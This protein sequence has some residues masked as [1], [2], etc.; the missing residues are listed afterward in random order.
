MIE[1]I[2]IHNFKSVDNLC[3]ILDNFNCLIGMNGVGKSTILQAIDFISQIMSGHVQ[4]W[5]D[6]RGWFSSD[7]GS[8]LI[9]K[10]HFIFS[11]SF[12]TKSG[13]DLK[14]DAKLDGVNSKCINERIYI[15]GQRCFVVSNELFVINKKKY[16]CSFIYQGSL[17]S[18]LKESELPEEILEF[19]T[20]LCSIRSLELLSPQLMR[21]RTRTS[22]QDIS[23]G[24]EKLSAYLHGIKGEKRERLVGLLKQFYPNL[25]DFKVTSQR[26]GWK[27]LSVIERYGE[28]N[29]ETEASHLSDGLLRI[30]A[31]LAQRESDKSLIMLDEIEN[32]INQEIVAK[33][34]EILLNAPQQILVTTHSPLILNYLE[35]DVAR[36][37]ALFMYKTPKG[38]SRM[39]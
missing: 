29:L 6:G 4:D 17:L 18:Q 31:I 28:R 24:G 26:A 11:V 20:A 12:R 34:V 21:K 2:E 13:D 30:L 27:K 35:D 9:K 1:K 37:A 7:L 25:I 10:R 8:K 38:Q 16:T 5:L 19:R 39:R 15:N 14:W 32:G 33:L 23:S 3:L 22:E 36:R